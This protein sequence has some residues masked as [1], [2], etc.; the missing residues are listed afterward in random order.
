MLNPHKLNYLAGSQ[1]DEINYPLS[2]YRG[3]LIYVSLAWQLR[4][5]SPS[6][7]ADVKQIPLD[8]DVPLAFPATYQDQRMIAQRSCF[9]I[10]GRSLDPL[11]DILSDKGVEMSEYLIEYQIDIKKARSLLK[12]LS[13]LG[14]SAATIFPDL[15]HLGSDLT[16]YLELFEPADK[17]L[18]LQHEQP[19]EDFMQLETM[20]GNGEVFKDGTSIAEVHYRIQ[21]TQQVHVVRGLSGPTEHVPGLQNK[22]G[23]LTVVTGEIPIGETLSLRLE[24]DS[25]WTF[26]ARSSDPLGKV[27]QVISTV[28]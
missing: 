27:F 19:L 20:N 11:K 28:E 8:L 15:D 23:Q 22:S 13:V 25:T 18:Y 5:L 10:H 9:T 6:Q 16:D 3:G 26:F 4:D 7:I 12:E 21:I 24:D 14:V 1:T 17:H 2:W